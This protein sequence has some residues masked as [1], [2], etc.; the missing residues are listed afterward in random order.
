MTLRGVILSKLQSTTQ[1]DGNVTCSQLAHVGQFWVALTRHFPR[2][3]FFIPTSQMSSLLVS[4]LPS[5]LPFRHGYCSVADSLLQDP[6]PLEEGGRVNHNRVQRTAMHICSNSRPSEL[7]GVNTEQSLQ[8]REA[9]IAP[10]F[11]PEEGAMLQRD[12]KK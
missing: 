9:Q 8:S 11:F 10:P 5:T 2:T 4:H 7:K 1:Q 3:H 12:C 6:K